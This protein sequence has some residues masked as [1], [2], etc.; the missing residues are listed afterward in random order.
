M[1]VFKLTLVLLLFQ[2]GAQ[3]TGLEEKSAGKAAIEGVVLRAASG[4]PLDRAEVRL[5]RVISEEELEINIF[6]G[7]PFTQGLPTAL[8]EKDGKFSLKDLE[9][10][11]YRL[12]ALRNGYSEQNYGQKLQDGPGRNLYLAPGET[13]KDVTFRLVQGGVVTGRIRNTIGEPVTG[14]TVQLL[15][16]RYGEDR[17]MLALVD[18]T[19]TDDRGEYRM[20]W[21]KPGRYYLKVQPQGRFG[22]SKAIPD[23]AI[24]SAYYPGTLD[25][26][27]ASTI[28]IQSGIERTA[29]I[30][31]PKAEGHW[32]RGRIVEESTG[33]PP[34]AAI[35]TLARR[36]SS[37]GLGEWEFD[38]T[39][40]DY[41]PATGSFSIR[42]ILPGPYWL[43]VNSVSGFDEPIPPDQ[44]AEVR[45]QSDLFTTVFAPS[46]SAQ[47]TLEMP[48]SDL[49]DVMARLT[50]G[51]SIP[52]RVTV[53]GPELSSI[54]DIDKVR[55][56]LT[57][58]GEG[59]GYREST[60]LSGDGA[61]RVNN[62]VPGEYRVSVGMP[63]AMDLYVKEILYG[64]MD[65]LHDPLQI[66]DQ[67]PSM[68][69]ILLSDK[70]GRVE[71][72]L[73]DAVGQPLG[74]TEVVLIPDLRERKSL[75]KTTTTDRD[76]HFVFRALAPGGYKLFSWEALESNAYYNQNV[77][78]KYEAD[79]KRV[80]IQESSKTTIDIK[81]IPE[82][83]Q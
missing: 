22:P 16:V 34:K 40:S 31:L 68:L 79:G 63:K 82:A 42:N 49:T 4:E 38:Q 1:T 30:I 43:S 27:S 60:R 11:P 39:R 62:V 36:Q 9:P 25:V 78:A 17:A 57:S 47:I 69:S 53:E 44:L 19:K 37:G 15:R 70:G 48:S 61:A 45:T 20:F 7:D 77:L 28:D 83:R 76:G 23:L 33:K 46:T 41:N 74:G 2:I 18:E 13:L 50:P 6:A 21:I 73:T 75:L 54:K 14:V 66:S 24:P 5:S 26:A 3:P 80:Q 64:R 81:S 52:A 55:I 71:G 10:G 72:T 59:P 12:T 29:D 65:V 8:T 56:N 58:P 35:I 67:P 32:V 51:M